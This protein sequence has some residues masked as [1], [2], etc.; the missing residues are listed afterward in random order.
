MTWTKIRPGMVPAMFMIPSIRAIGSRT[1]WNGMKQPNSI[2]EK[3][4]FAP[5]NFHWAMT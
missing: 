3:I 5:L 2:S 4:R 1:T